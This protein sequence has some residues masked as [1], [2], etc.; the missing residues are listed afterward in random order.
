MSRFAAMVGRHVLGLS[1][2][3][4]GGGDVAYAKLTGTTTIL[5]GGAE[6]VYQ[7]IAVLDPITVAEGDTYVLQWQGLARWVESGGL[8]FEIAIEVMAP[9]E[10]T[11]EALNDAAAFMV[12]TDDNASEWAH[13]TGLYTATGD[14]EISFRLSARND[15]PNDQF[16][17]T[18]G[19]L[20]AIKATRTP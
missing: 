20:L 8:E 9:G 11:W 2:T 16:I 13:V 4:G 3:G 15:T 5:G 7:P 19:V 18:I 17:D 10:S 6:G 12:D 1:G 14:G